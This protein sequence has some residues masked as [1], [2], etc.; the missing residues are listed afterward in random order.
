MEKQQHAVSLREEDIAGLRKHLTAVRD[1][2]ERMKSQPLSF[3]EDLHKV[4]LELAKK[5]A[6][7]QMLWEAKEEMKLQLEVERK[8][9]DG[10]LMQ[11]TAAMSSD[12]N[13]RK[14]VEVSNNKSS[15]CIQ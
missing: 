13:Y 14:E 12:A 11:Q 15:I 8:R 4:T 10:Y 6:E 1:E 7:V 5:S 3:Q 2:M 9:I